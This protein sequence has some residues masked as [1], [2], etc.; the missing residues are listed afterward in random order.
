M[1]DLDPAHNTHAVPRYSMDTGTAALEKTLYHG[2]VSE[3]DLI[4]IKIKVEAE[5]IGRI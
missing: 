2:T 5:F 1:I 4:H 3:R